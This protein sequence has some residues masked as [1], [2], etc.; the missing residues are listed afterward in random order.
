MKS[1]F[2]GTYLMERITHCSVL[3][4]RS[5]NTVGPPRVCLSQQLFL[6]ILYVWSNIFLFISSF[7]DLQEGEVNGM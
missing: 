5:F 3:Y 2:I 1:D 6:T 4:S 7:L